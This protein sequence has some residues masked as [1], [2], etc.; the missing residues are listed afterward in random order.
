MLDMV[1]LTMVRLF[2]SR[3]YYLP[4]RGMDYVGKVHI[5][6]SL[7]WLLGF[8][9]TS[10]LLVASI[11]LVAIAFLGVMYGVCIPMFLVE[12]TVFLC[13]YLPGLLQDMRINGLQLHLAVGPL[14]LC[15]S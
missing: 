14:L 6:L 7:Y 13:P 12:R 8:R 9:H 2:Q 3:A 1:L 11:P 5:I 4:A 10:S 15:L